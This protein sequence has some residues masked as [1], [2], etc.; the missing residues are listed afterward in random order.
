MHSHH[1]LG[2]VQSHGLGDKMIAGFLP[3]ALKLG[4]PAV[5]TDIAPYLIPYS[6]I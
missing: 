6:S 5:S 3:R 4:I 1:V 2:A